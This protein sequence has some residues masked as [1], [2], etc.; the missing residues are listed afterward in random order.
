MSYA[1]LEQ[2]LSVFLDRVASDE[3]APGGGACAAVTVGLA[4]GL[5]AM[6]ARFSSATVADAA[7]VVE[8]AEALRQR[9]QG[10]AQQD[11]EAYTQG[12]AGLPLPKSPDPDGRRQQIAAALSAAAEPPLA[13]A[14]AAV[15]VGRLARRLE[16][17]GN[18]NLRGDAVTGRLLA[19]AGCRAAGRAGRGE[20]ARRGATARAGRSARRLVG[21][22]PDERDPHRRS[23]GSAR[24]ARRAR[25][26][27]QGAARQPGG[28]RSGD[29]AGGR[30][31]RLPGLR[32]AGADARGVGRAA[33]TSAPGLDV[34]AEQAD[35]LAVVGGLNAD[36]RISGILVLRPAAAAPLG[37][38]DLP[39]A[40]PRQGHRGGASAERRAARAGRP[41][42]IPSTPAS[43][44]YLLDHHLA[45]TE[46]DASA[47][48]A[49]SC[50]VV[51]GRSNNVGKPASLLGMQ[52]GATVVSCDVNTS[53]AGRLRE[54]T[55]QAD[56]L[57]VAVGVPG[58]IGPDDVKDGAVVI[59]VGIN[60][61]RGDDGRTRMVGDVQPEVLSR[62]SA[63]TPVPG[64]VGPITD[65]WLLH[66][67][68]LAAQLRAGAERG[69]PSRGPTLAWDTDPT[70]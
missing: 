21:G 56:V 45:R 42:F 37:S 33:T 40:R 3:P 60:P 41:R 44:F 48:Y 17:E 62:A 59:D 25:A 24:A 36:P 22:W 35:L 49:R 66:N 63:M 57:I 16:A 58:L 65:V 4:A 20:P 11:A 70:R 55:S 64:G 51:L 34:D 29:R 18:P 69:D 7:S 26:R 32:A 47:F 67:T 12:P 6:A 28:A 10:L 14:E 31:L 39:D 54:F 27:G 50:I 43:C 2:P 53:R 61:V 8:Q 15:E 46:T 30:R 1:F 9:V 52:R 13:V 23:C 19:E 68:V 38:R 5:C